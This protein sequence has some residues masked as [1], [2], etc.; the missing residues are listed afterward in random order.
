MHEADAATRTRPAFRERKK[1]EKKE[2]KENS[3]GQRRATSLIIHEA[4]T[5]THG[6]LPRKKIVTSMEGK[7]GLEA[8]G[9]T[10]YS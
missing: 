9:V 8:G 5:A 4:A 1:K 6:I 3:R 2:K 10:H 7:Q